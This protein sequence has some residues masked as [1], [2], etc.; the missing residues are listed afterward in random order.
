M[1]LYYSFS[2]LIVLATI[3]E[4]INHRLLRLPSAIG[5]MIIAVSISL[6]LAMF[7]DALLPKTTESLISLITKIDFTEI[8]D[9]SDALIFYF[10]RLLFILIL[11]ICGRISCLL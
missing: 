1:E 4:F 10:L 8:F 5:I 3:F 11:R 2:I 9:G 7:G 6:I